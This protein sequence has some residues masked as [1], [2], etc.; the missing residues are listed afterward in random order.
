MVLQT[1][2]I[3]E[4]GSSE[5]LSP[6]EAD[7]EPIETPEQ[8]PVDPTV[9][10]D[11]IEVGGEETVCVCDETTH[12]H[13]VGNFDYDIYEPFV[14]NIVF[15]YTGDNVTKVTTNNTFGTIVTDFT[16]IG[17]DVSQISINK[18]GSISRFVT[19]VKQGDIITQINIT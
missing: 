12:V 4:L 11:A 7:I 8:I 10:T 19:F 1:K 6:I 9:L 2:G 18:Y 5:N 3:V 14:G 13:G 16:Y 17:D 15:T